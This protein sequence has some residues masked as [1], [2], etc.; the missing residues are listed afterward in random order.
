LPDPLHRLAA[1]RLDRQNF[2]IFASRSLRHALGFL[3]LDYLPK[4]ADQSRKIVSSPPFIR[5][6]AG[7]ENAQRCV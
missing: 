1:S 3:P 6:A 7:L 2:R 4:E 5:T